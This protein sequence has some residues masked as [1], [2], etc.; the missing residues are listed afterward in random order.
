MHRPPH[1]IAPRFVLPALLLALAAP[2]VARAASAVLTQPE[3]ERAVREAG[4]DP[5]AIDNPIGFTPEMQEFARR[6]AG[7][8]T[9]RERLDRLQQYLF[10]ERHL[11]FDY[12]NSFT[13]TARDAWTRQGGNCVS[14]TNLFIALARSIDIPVQA[15][16]FHREGNP[17]MD[18]DLRIFNTHM[19][20][21]YRDGNQIVV[22]DFFYLR[23]EREFG[24]HLIGDLDNTG[25][26][27]S[28]RGTA[29]LRSGDTGEA[30]R[31]LGMAV[32]V[33]PGFGSA[34]GNLG[35]V[36]R[37][38]GDLDGALVSHLTAQRLEPFDHRVLGNL[39][40]TLSDWTDRYALEH[41]AWTV[42]GT[43][44]GRVVAGLRELAR[45]ANREAC[46]ML[47]E[48]IDIDAGSGSARAAHVLCLVVRG[49]SR[50]AR[51]AMAM[52]ERLDDEGTD[53][54]RVRGI[55]DEVE[56]LRTGRRRP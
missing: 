53:V 26:Y 45:G 56:R 48:A 20:A 27:L 44:A 31:L 14:F 15:A 23:R 40:R 11:R 52:A 9:D 8:G 41:P 30:L 43:T 25:V 1:R 16:L 42:E 7:S 33:A 29:A 49:K 5:E 38:T 17:E 28:N 47:E 54:L 3:W 51:R 19:A 22:F 35:V 55:L 18:G 13:L 32:A 12:E 46:R 50:A 36:R 34:H 39:R 37:R 4:V 2:P 10:D 24:F 21:G 6:I